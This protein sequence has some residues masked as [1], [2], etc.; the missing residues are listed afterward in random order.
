MRVFISHSSTDKPAV[1]ELA[2]ALRFRGFEPWV[3]KWEIAPGDD[4]VAKINQ[5]LEQ[6]DA[7]LIVFSAGAAKSRWVQAE[8]S[9]L[10]F[11][12]IESGQVLIPLTFDDDAAMPPL[13]APLLR[14]RIDEVEAI[15][16]ALHGPPCAALPMTAR[17]SSNCA[18]TSRA[19]RWPTSVFSST[20]PGR[21]CSG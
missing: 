10:T 7:G 21:W 16:D 1:L 18:A 11:A 13:L 12:R 3:D 4:I 2:D 15:A 6:A 20:A 9:A 14:R 8:W 5:G 19:R 17:H